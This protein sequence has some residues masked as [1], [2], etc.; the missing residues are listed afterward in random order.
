MNQPKFSIEDFKL[1]DKRKLL[2]QRDLY[3][4]DDEEVDLDEIEVEEKQITEEHKSVSCNDE[5]DQWSHEIRPPMS[6]REIYT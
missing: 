5:G 4:H 6:D 2:N 3:D 1:L